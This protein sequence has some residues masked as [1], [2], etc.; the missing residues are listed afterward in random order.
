MY[1]NKQA[2]IEQREIGSDT[3]TW[4]SALRNVL[5]Q[6]PDVIVLGELRDLESIQVALL[7]AETG[8]L[9]MA[10]VHA[11]TATGAVSRLIDVFPP[12]QIGQVRLQLSQSLRMIFAQ[13]LV[14]G[15]AAETRALLFET[16]IGTPAIANLIRSGELE[17]IPN[18]I[19]AGREHGMISFAQCQRDLTARGLIHPDAPLST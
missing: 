9:V 6:A 14:P 5:R 10:S 2:I 8:H 13:R 15:S 4:H 12:S 7:A 19:A 3:K 11:S 16:L 18:M 17:Q 1:S